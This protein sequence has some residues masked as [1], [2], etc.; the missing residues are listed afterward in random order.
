MDI[1]TI[2]ISKETKEKL[3]NLKKYPRETD[4]ETL[5][6]IIKKHLNSKEEMKNENN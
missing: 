5:L 4:E 3:K 6:R 2:R 1:T